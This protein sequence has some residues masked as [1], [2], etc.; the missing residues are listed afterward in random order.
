L[1]FRLPRSRL[2]TDSSPN[3]PADVGVRE[4]D[5]WRLLPRLWRG[6]ATGVGFGGI[7]PAPEAG[8]APPQTAL[9]M[10]LFGIWGLRFLVSGFWF[11]VKGLSTNQGPE[12]GDLVLL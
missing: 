9:P 7:Y 3:E 10:S 12:K 8:P 11:R 1:K 6:R 2:S 4:I 5:F